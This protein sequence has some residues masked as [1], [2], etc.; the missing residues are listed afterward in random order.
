MENRVIDITANSVD[1]TVTT[2]EIDAGVSSTEILADVI[3]VPPV[4]GT[5]SD[6]NIQVNLTGFGEEAVPNGALFLRP[7]PYDHIVHPVE[8]VQ[9]A[10]AKGFADAVAQSDEFRQLYNKAQNEIVNTAD[11]FS[12]LVSFSRLFHDNARYFLQDYL[13]ENHTYTVYDFRLV[14]EASFDFQKRLLDTSTV[15]EQAAKL[16]QTPKT[17]TT[18]ASDSSFTVTDFQR[19]VSELVDATDDVL[20]EANIDDD[21]IA[22]VG[23]V[24]V[25]YATLTETFVAESSTVL[26]DTF[27]YSD[28]AALLVQKPFTEPAN[29]IIEQATLALDKLVLEAQATSEVYSVVL[30][31]P[32]VDSI[33]R[34]DTS[35]VLYEALKLDS[36]AASEFDSKLVEQLKLEQVAGS[37]EASKAI[38]TVYSDTYAYS[39]EFRAQYAKVALDGVQQSDGYYIEYAKS[40]LESLLLA[41]QVA[42]DFS[43][44]FSD[45][46]LIQELVL[47]TT[48]W[49]RNFVEQVLQQDLVTLVYNKQQNELISTSEQLVLVYE[50]LFTELVDATDDFYG[51]ANIDDDQVAAVNKVALDYAT[52]ADL[53]I[54]VTDFQRIPTEVVATSEIRS[55]DA[56]TVYS[57]QTTNADQVGKLIDRYQTNADY[58]FE[59]YVGSD[60]YIEPHWVRISDVDSMQLWIQPGAADVV[61]MVESVI[62]FD[63]IHG[64]EEVGTT[65]EII[66]KALDYNLS[67]LVDATDDFYGVANL[68][69]D[70]IASVDKVLADYG[71]T[72]DS[73]TTKTE[74][75]RQFADTA[76]NTDQPSKQVSTVYS[77]T[78]TNSEV[79]TL[80]AAFNRNI[81]DQAASSDSVLLEYTINR[82]YY[83]AYSASDSIA[84]LVNKV[85]QDSTSGAGDQASYEVAKVLADALALANQDQAALTVAKVLADTTNATQDLV[86]LQ[87]APTKV[88]TVTNSETKTANIQNFF[89]S[90]FAQTGYVGTNLTL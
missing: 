65:S 50:Q 85:L 73:I 54:T 19:V 30:N 69:D 81:L 55:F 74:F 29:T 41:E 64:I 12:R 23:K 22:T 34:S 59:S 66:T 16:F 49:I 77:D 72:G 67:D 32:L 68:D 86:T 47:T 28:S 63:S 33:A 57:D 14:D 17:D 89:Q 58:F 7:N 62:I 35:S 46:A 52:L 87:A 13:T 8:E 45:S 79:F 24:L 25:D 51:E 15:A 82:F 71:T 3:A 4:T 84:Q 48:D 38:E 80:E 76:N 26:S 9:K 10:A 5:Q 1:A 31:K 61:G 78:A 53:V 83:D 37:E 75:D 40:V 70:Q 2:N 18:T 60:D 88:D 56:Q 39:D 42:V 27:A 11:D 44:I 20:G 6:F 43:K 21:Q 90:N 36:T